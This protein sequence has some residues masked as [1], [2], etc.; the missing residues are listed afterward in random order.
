MDIIMHKEVNWLESNKFYLPE[1]IRKQFTTNEFAVIDFS[2]LDSLDRENIFDCYDYFSF[3]AKEYYKDKLSELLDRASDDPYAY[4]MFKE[5]E[6]SMIEI[7]MDDDGLVEIPRWYIDKLKAC[8]K[9]FGD[10]IAVSYSF[11]SVELV[12]P[13]Y[14]ENHPDKD[15]T[16]EEL[17]NELCISNIH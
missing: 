17:V 5:I 11:G 9:V 6:K 8:G 3:R 12:H 13:L 4:K 2:D 14:Y 16:V 15:K 1:D 7:N 10:T